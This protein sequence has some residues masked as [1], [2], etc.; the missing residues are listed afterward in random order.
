MK[1]IKCRSVTTP[2]YSTPGSNGLDFYVPDDFAEFC[3]NPNQ[4]VK[5]PSGIKVQLP[6]EYA[7]LA[8]N[9]SSV[10]SKGVVVGATLVDSDYR[11]EIHISLV[12]SGNEPFIIHPGAKIVQ[13]CYI[14]IPQ[15]ELEEVDEFDD[16]TERGGGGF[17]STG[18]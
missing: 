14:H 7:L 2:H 6:N 15:V 18:V 11:G 10:G 3:L 1:F 17:G 13:F 9:R 5:I 4:V 16:I 8:T 12:N